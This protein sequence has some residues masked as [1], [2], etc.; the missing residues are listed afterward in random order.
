M[1]IQTIAK[2]NIK[3]INYDDVILVFFCRIWSN[4]RSRIK[5][6]LLSF[7][8]NTIFSFEKIIYNMYNNIKGI[9]SM[10]KKSKLLEELGKNM[11]DI[12]FESEIELE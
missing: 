1:K 3:D 6:R 2:D 10:A 11:K 5:S 9:R 4:R 12:K 8:D 7:L